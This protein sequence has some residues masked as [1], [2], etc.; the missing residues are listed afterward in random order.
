MKPSAKR[1]VNTTLFIATIIYLVLEFAFN[2]HLLNV[3]GRLASPSAIQRLEFYGRVLAATGLAVFIIHKAMSGF[4][5]SGSWLLVAVLAWPVVFFGEKRGI[6][7]LSHQFTNKEEAAAYTA[8]LLREGMALHA[9]DLDGIPYGRDKNPA[10]DKTLLAIIGLATVANTK[11]MREIDANMMRMALSIARARAVRKGDT[12]YL[13]Y[14]RFWNAIAARYR[15][16]YVPATQ[17]Y[18]EAMARADYEARTAWAQANDNLARAGWSRYRMGV[19]RYHDQIRMQAERIVPRLTYFFQMRQDC[20]NVGWCLHDVDARYAALA[21]KTFGYAVPWTVWCVPLKKHWLTLPFH[22]T[23]NG[24]EKTDYI[25]IG[26]E[27][28]TDTY[29]CNPTE[30]SVAHRLDSLMAT[31]FEAETGYPP[32]IKSRPAFIGNH[33]SIRILAKVANKLG[34]ELPSNWTA[35]QQ[36]TWERAVATGIQQRIADR[37]Y[38]ATRRD[39]GSRIPPGLNWI[40]FADSVAVRHTVV[41]RFGVWAPPGLAATEFSRYVLPA[42]ERRVAARAV[43]TDHMILAGRDAPLGRAVLL[44]M[45]VPPI[46]LAFSLFFSILNTFNIGFDMLMLLRAPVVRSVPRA[47]LMLLATLMIIAVP[48]AL[49]NPISRAG[50]FHVLV[51]AMEANTGTGAHVLGWLIR[52]EPAFYTLGGHSLLLVKQAENAML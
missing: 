28:K 36:A 1:M 24:R 25:G 23:W 32:G 46:A 18:E 6:T 47:I 39:F 13:G 43:A 15:H 2:A 44:S 42:W 5:L 4:R 52:A 45:I 37:W 48:F 40:S 12:P 16:D 33:G 19:M 7:W 34:A 22:V 38:R 10:A 17:K 8:S 27:E 30:V 11:F 50:P 20:G 26:P 9:V 21:R 41:A 31:R 14:I 49:S 51:R 3:V 35:S 29:T